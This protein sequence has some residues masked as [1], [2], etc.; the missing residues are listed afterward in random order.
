MKGNIKLSLVQNA[1]DEA[2][3]QNKEEAERFSSIIN[4]TSFQ[5]FIKESQKM[6]NAV[7]EAMDRLRPAFDFKFKAQEMAKSLTESLQF[8][9]IDLMPK[10]ENP[11]F[12]ISPP[13]KKY[14]EEE[15]HDLIHAVI[16]KTVKIMANKTLLNKLDLPKKTTWEDIVIKFKDGHNVQILA[17][18]LVYNA[19]YKEMGFEDGNKLNPNQQ[20]QFLK[21]LA[22]AKGEIC[23]KQSLKPERTQKIKQLLAKGLKEYFGLKDDPFI[24]HRKDKIYQLK[25]KLLPE[26]ESINLPAVAYEVKNDDEFGIN[27]YLDEMTTPQ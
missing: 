27:D 2:I 16:E 1:M 10:I 23:W 7:S 13:K 4:T 14:T 21:G 20:W 26:S 8:P 3:K 24:T 11:E 17:G 9:K 12:L 22:S 19:N 15:I 6:T 5:Q 18:E 25:F